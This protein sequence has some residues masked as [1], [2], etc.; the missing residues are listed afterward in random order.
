M[1][2]IRGRIPAMPKYVITF[3]IGVSSDSGANPKSGPDITKEAE[4]A[5]DWLLT[6]LPRFGCRMSGGGLDHDNSYIAYTEGSDGEEGIIFFIPAYIYIETH[7]ELSRVIA[8]ISEHP[9]VPTGVTKGIIQ[10]R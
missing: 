5:L 8:R 9:A 7:E 1:R 2:A 6:S 4:L 3:P 10:M